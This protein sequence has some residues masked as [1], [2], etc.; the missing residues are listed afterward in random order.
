MTS[1]QISN[2]KLAIMGGLPASEK[3]YSVKISKM[4]SLYR[5][6]KKNDLQDNLKNF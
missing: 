1:K 6:Y 4:I 3:K 2:L 5:N